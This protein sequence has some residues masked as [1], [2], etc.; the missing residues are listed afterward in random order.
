MS[1]K[2]V[3]NLKVLQNMAKA[4]VAV[5]R[6]LKEDMARELGLNVVTCT[7]KIHSEYE[8]FDGKMFSNDSETKRG[9]LDLTIDLTKNKETD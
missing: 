7:V 5:S 3:G 4:S 9:T 6:Q 2:S 8:S 1:D